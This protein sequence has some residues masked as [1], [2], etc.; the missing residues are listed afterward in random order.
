M[1]PL[2]W[3]CPLPGGGIA[4]EYALAFDQDRDSRLLIV[5]ALFDEANRMRR[6]TVE[7][8]RRLDGAGIDCILP[9][10]PGCNESLQLLEF[11]SAD[12]WRDAME[13]AALHFGATHV[14]GFRGGCMFAPVNLPCWHYAPV[15][16]AN[17]LRQMVRAPML[18]SREAGHE[19]KREELMALAADQ[20]IELAG[21]RL[22]SEFIREFEKLVPANSETIQLIDQD[23]I[24]GSGLWL[25]AEPGES[26]EQADALAAVLAMGIRS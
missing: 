16:G 13:A 20:G 11:Q 14:L 9:D 5:P 25:R 19:E 3:P 22:G 12:D 23:M 2:S 24:G 21:Y 17:V 15:K 4:E 6:L 1:T 8:M 26:S 10:L 18:A 7:V